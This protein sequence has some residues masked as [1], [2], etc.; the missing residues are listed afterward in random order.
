MLVDV[1]DVPGE[2]LELRLDESVLQQPPSGLSGLIRIGEPNA[3]DAVDLARV[4]ATPVA[5][6]VEL[7]L[8]EHNFTVVRLPVSVRPTERATVEF[9][10][11]EVALEAP[12][13]T[14]TCWSLEPERVDEEIKVATTVGITS[15]L[16][17]QLAE[18]NGSNQKNSEYVIRQPRVLAYQ[19]GCP[20]PAWEFTP[21]PGRRLEGVQ[22]LHLVVKSP[23]GAAW[24]GKVG[25]RVGVHTGGWPWRLRAVRRDGNQSVAQFTHPAH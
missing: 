17:V 9:L 2:D 1:D 7:L 20:D 14:A 23:R 22:L 10:A 24:T 8:A 12:G 6:E 18:V 25:I 5:P 3:F 19:V 4:S 15:K 16:S 13:S 21:T 11:V